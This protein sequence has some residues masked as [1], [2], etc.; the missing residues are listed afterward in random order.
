M[1]KQMYEHTFSSKKQF[2]KWLEE[3]EDKI[4][5]DWEVEFAWHWKEKDDEE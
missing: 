5:W 2:F 1:T 3:N 4:D